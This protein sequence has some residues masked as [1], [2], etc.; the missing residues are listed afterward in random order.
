MSQGAANRGAGHGLPPTA[1]ELYEQVKRIVRADHPDWGTFALVC[2]KCGTSWPQSA[3]MG[4]VQTHM[5]ITHD[6][7][8]VVLDLVWIGEGRPPEAPR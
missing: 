4:M 7:D 6:T 3:E 5:Q 1:R 2:S 8:D